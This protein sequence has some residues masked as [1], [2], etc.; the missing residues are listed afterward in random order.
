[1]GSPMAAN[2]EN[3][4]MDMFELSFLND[5]Y[6]ETGKKPSMWLRFIDDIFFIL[7]HGKESL[8]RICS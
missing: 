8:K 6:K 1:M 5:F 7:T 4:F 2:Y 3:L